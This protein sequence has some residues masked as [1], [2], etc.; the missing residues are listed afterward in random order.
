MSDERIERSEQE[1]QGT[2]RP[3]GNRVIDDLLPAELLG[4]IVLGDANSPAWRDERFAEFV[5]RDRREVARRERRWS[6]ADAL[7][8]GAQLRARVLASTLGVRR[9]ESVPPLRPRLVEGSA[10]AVLEHA[11]EVGACPFVD[12]AVA[13]GAGRALWDDDVEEWVT[14]PRDLPRARYL[15]LRIAGGS[16]APL[17]HHGD[18]VLVAV[19]AAPRASSVIVAR[20][21]DDGYVCKR[22]RRV[23]GATIE[24]ESLDAAYGGLTI[25]RDDRLIVGAVRAVWCAHE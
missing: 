22:V 10:S 18:T 14:L 7:E 19:G 24:L 23:R 16:M 11:L 25:P 9:M 21:A 13:A 20:H 15:A 5:A 1:G 4:R 6:D 3:L 2:M 12:L 8:A 17:L